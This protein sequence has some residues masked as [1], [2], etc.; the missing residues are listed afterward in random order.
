MEKVLEVE[1]KL[2]DNGLYFIPTGYKITMKPE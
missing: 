2:T 1:P